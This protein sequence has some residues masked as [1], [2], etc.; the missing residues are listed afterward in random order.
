[1][2]YIFT[3]VYAYTHTSLQDCLLLFFYIEAHITLRI[4]TRRGQEHEESIFKTTTKHE[5]E[6]KV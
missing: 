1:M 4:I 3:A 5:N 2:K 6:Q